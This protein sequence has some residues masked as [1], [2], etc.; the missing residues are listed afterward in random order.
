MTSV[1]SAST[2]PT[3]GSASPAAPTPSDPGRPL[4]G[5]SILAL[6]ALGAILFVATLY[7]AFVLPLT[8]NRI[9]RPSAGLVDVSALW[10]WLAGLP[11]PVPGD[12][13][14]VAVSL[15][16]FGALSI[17]AYCLAVLL[18]WRRAATRRALAVVLVPASIILVVS[19]VALPTQSSDIVDY[20]L[21]GRVAAVYGESP[22]VVPPDAFPDDPL[23]PYASGNYT[24]DTEAKPPVWI[25]GAVGAAA[26]TAGLGPAEMVLVGRFLF[27][28]LT[29]LN[30]GLIAAVLAR[31]RPEHLVTGLVLFAWSPIVAMHG[32]FR[33]DTLMV[34]FALLGA[35]LLVYGRYSAAM[36]ALTVSVLVKLLTLPMLAVSVLGDLVARRWRQVLIT[37]LIAVG[38]TILVYLPFDGGVTRVMEHLGFGSSVGGTYPPSLRYLFLG[39]AVL[40]VLWGG[41]HARGEIEGTLQGWALVGL[42]SIPLAPLGWAWYVLVPIAVVSLSGERRKTAL[43]VAMSSV[44]FVAD[45]WVRTDSDRYPL[46]VPL[47]LS[48]TEAVI[49]AVVA[50]AILAIGV[51][52]VQRVRVQ[53]AR[54]A[55]A[56]AAATIESGQTS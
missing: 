21:S 26:L 53:S 4:D 10:T 5:R 28:A 18:T 1:D 29:F 32:P 39:L 46:P 25:A 51:A 41:F 16:A 56:A 15:L 20:L 11:W 48:R 24:S 6:A 8:P 49:L 52:I 47:G 2:A 33:F 17:G 43:L 12:A 44:A 31:W 27:L 35:L 42:A 7:Y 19:A 40:A 55:T 38:I 54:R 22:Y 37:G 23:R 45:T 30:I 50:V 34:T 36:A 3:G 9:D 13:T 14:T